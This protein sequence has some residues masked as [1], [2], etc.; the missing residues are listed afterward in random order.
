MNQIRWLF[1][2]NYVQAEA[3]LHCDPEAR[4]YLTNRLIVTM[5]EQG[6]LEDSDR[7]KIAE[8]GEY[9]GKLNKSFNSLIILWGESSFDNILTHYF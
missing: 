8:D 1:L 2:Q 3:L 5:D 7:S 6:S 4:D 9:Q